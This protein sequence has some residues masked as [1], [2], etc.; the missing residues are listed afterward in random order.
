AKKAT[1]L[2]TMIVIFGQIL[3]TPIHAQ[4]LGRISGT[5]TDQTGAVVIGATVLAM[6]VETGVKTQ[7]TTNE[8]GNYN[9]PALLPGRYRVEAEMSGFKKYVREPVLISTATPVGLNIPMEVGELSSE[10]SVTGAPPLLQTEEQSLSTVLEDKMIRDLPVALNR[11]QAI[12]S[13]RRQ[14]TAFIF[15]TPGVSG[16]AFSTEVNGMQVGTTEIQADGGL[17]GTSAVFGRTGNSTPPYDAVGEFK[18]I[19]GIP[20]AEDGIGSSTI[21]LT[22]KSGTNKIHGSVNEYIR[23]D[24][25]DARGFFANKVPI[26]RQNEYGFTVGGPVFIPKVYNGKD[27][28]FF[29][30]TWGGFKVRGGGSTRVRTFPTEAF[31]RGDFS[32]LVDP[33]GNLIPI[34]DPLSAPND[35]KS[36]RTQFPG[37]IIPPERIN[38]GA[39]KAVQL[40]P[41]A[42]ID[43]PFNNF[44]GE[45]SRSLDDTPWSVKIDHIF[46]QRHKISG[47]F[48]YDDYS[49]LQFQPVPGPTSDG[50]NILEGGGGLKLS[51]NWTISPSMENELRPGWGRD[52]RNSDSLPGTSLGPSGSNPLGIKNFP[53]TDGSFVMGAEGYSRGPGGSGFFYNVGDTAG[54]TPTD[55][56]QVSDI[57]TWTKSKHTFKF[58][59]DYRQNK[60][61]QGGSG[62]AFDDF[63]K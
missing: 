6:N 51:Y 44:V 18:V 45:L 36:A 38:P 39:L 52:R 21:K 59:A 47:S 60:E 49:I 54:I 61:T 62:A 48:W 57:L 5:V 28:T 32:K 41:T 58:G 63:R 14:P 50:Y 26:V 24:V 11:D 35:G 4:N 2:L 30:F 3:G 16:N 53:F 12:A 9:I 56:Y 23:N 37:N 10:V 7:T 55:T 40:M 43:K 15:L 31:K 29:F 27:K 8:S 42:Q 13:G 34:F 22:L 46:N 17:S 1:L 20:D 33:Q 19:Q 25:F